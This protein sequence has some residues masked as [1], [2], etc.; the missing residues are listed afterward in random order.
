[1]FP[2]GKYRATTKEEPSDAVA[3]PTP[4]LLLLFHTIAVKWPVASKMRKK[5][6]KEIK[7]RK[8]KQRNRLCDVFKAE[9]SSSKYLQTKESQFLSRS[10]VRN[11]V[12]YFLLFFLLKDTCHSQCEIL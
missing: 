10:S 6:W 2:A 3:L 9:C 7:G 4:S 8:A 5:N 1:M 11:L 12:V